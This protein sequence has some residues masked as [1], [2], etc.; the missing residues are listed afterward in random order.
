[1]EELKFNCVCPKCTKKFVSN[2]GADYDG[3]AFCFDCIAKNKE[4]AA[5]VDAIIAQKRAKAD[6]PKVLGFDYEKVRN[7][8]NKNVVHFMNI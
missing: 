3:E 5:K 8:K 6:K 7:C 4:I 1:M 2:N